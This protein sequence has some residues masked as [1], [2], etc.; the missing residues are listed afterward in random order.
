M[1]YQARLL[2]GVRRVLAVL[3]RDIWDG[4]LPCAFRGEGMN[5]PGISLRNL[6]SD[7]RANCVECMGNNK[8]D[9]CTSES[10]RFKKYR[11]RVLQYNLFGDNYKAVW[12]SEALNLALT[13][14]INEPFFTSQFHQKMELIM[15]AAHP[16]WYGVL[17]GVTGQMIKHDFEMVRSDGGSLVSRKIPVELNKKANGRTEHCWKYQPTRQEIKKAL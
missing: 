16:N 17:F 12:F 7:I 4:N 8:R 14:F 9:I 6:L 10:C 5:D 2:G 1:V 13:S 11:T 3:G 15:P